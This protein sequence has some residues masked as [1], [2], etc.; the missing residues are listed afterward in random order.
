[1]DE[2]ADGRVDKKYITVLV[3]I[4]I[5]LP[6]SITASLR[7]IFHGPCLRKKMRCNAF[8]DGKFPVL[9]RQSV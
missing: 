2:V 7:V 9:T 1:M 3:S 5:L 4:R 8:H 6:S